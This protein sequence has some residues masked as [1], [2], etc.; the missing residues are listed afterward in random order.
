MDQE[1][2]RKSPRMAL[3]VPLSVRG[4][5][6]DGTPW[7]ERVT[8]L[9]TS[10]GGIAFPSAHPLNKGQIVFL[11]L[12]L[13]RSLREFDFNDPTYRVYALV[14]NTVA[15]DSGLRV[16][17]MFFGKMPPRGYDKN[18][19][20]RFL[21]PWDAPEDEPR[22]S[23][24]GRPA[25]E[26]AAPEADPNDRRRGPRHDVFVN[27]TLQQEDEWGTVLQEELTVT[28][29]IGKGGARVMTSLPFAKGDIVLVQD[30]GAAFQ[31]RAEVREVEPANG[32]VRKLSIKFLDAPPP[33]V[34]L[35][36]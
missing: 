2:R 3:G 31:T 33:D 20:A 1:D 35:K 30:Q 34:L 23:A 21:L 4:H 5:E 7:E 29:N 32:R 26:P 10:G 11:S 15:T 28:E 19:T 27:L 25:P 22:P 9:D 13:P 24:A 16:G 12:P 14:R 18:P 8:T 36:R 6:P 17:V